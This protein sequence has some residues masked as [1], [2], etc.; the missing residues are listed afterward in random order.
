MSKE[1]TEK[2]EDVPKV[3]ATAEIPEEIGEEKVEEEKATKKGAILLFNRWSFD[4]IEVKDLSLQNYINLTPVIIPHSGGKHQHKKFWKTEHI[5]IVERFINKIMTPGLVGKRIK[6]RGASANMGKK[7]KVIK[8]V[9]NAFAFIEYKTGENPI[10][11]L[12]KAIEHAAPREETTRIS[13]GGIS[14]QQ[15][16]DIAPQRRIDLSLKI[17]VQSTVGLTYNNIKTIDE[18]LAN[19]LILAS[20]NDAGSRAVKRKDEIERVAISAR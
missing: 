9:Y 15:A 18:I 17:I 12:V 16:V 7:Q 2:V 19:E 10:Q 13:M 6:G 20:R 5:S 4:G 11:V 1:E 3:E 8:I 14:Y